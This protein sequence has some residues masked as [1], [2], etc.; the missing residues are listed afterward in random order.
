MRWGREEAGW[1][2]TAAARLHCT[3]VH[4]AKMDRD[5]IL[6]FT[7]QRMDNTFLDCFSCTAK[8]D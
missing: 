1:P 8:Q 2:E 6:A 3:T 7:K 5:M 4:Y